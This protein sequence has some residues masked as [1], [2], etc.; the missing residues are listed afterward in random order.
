MKNKTWPLLLIISLL[1]GGCISLFASSSPDGLEK[2][3]ENQG[4]IQT[5][6]SY[7]TGIIP[8]YAFPG[9]ENEHVATALAGMIGTLV[10]FTILF[11]FNILIFKIPK[12]SRQ[13]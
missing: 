7:I 6:T 3:A 2:V 10:T 12:E 9:I 8:D 5:A 4:F 1:I 11:G 13:K